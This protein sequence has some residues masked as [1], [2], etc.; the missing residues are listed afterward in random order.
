MGAKA[1]H[2]PTTDW[3]MLAHAAD[4]RGTAQRLSLDQLL[5]RYMPPMRR[6]LL[7]CR[8]VNPQHVDDLI[9]SF[10]TERV[11]ESDLLKNAD[12]TRGRFR[13]LLIRALTNYV[14]DGHR[15]EKAHRTGPVLQLTD[16]A[17]VV[18]RGESDP[19]VYFERV[20]AEH[21]TAE[22]LERTRLRLA[23]TDR[24]RVWEVFSR[25]VLS[26]A[27]AE[28]RELAEQYQFTTLTKCASALHAAKRIFARELRVVLAE[29]GGENADINEELRDLKNIFARGR[30]EK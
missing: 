7:G 20:W 23:T 1:L 14:I 10:I 22:A 6:F 12:R 17:A 5:R 19:S 4:G 18:A 21:V 2:F 13:S 9:Q 26:P 25:R 3:S 24:D 28:Y 30:A 11:I 29:F 15:R 16:D 8:Q 27:T